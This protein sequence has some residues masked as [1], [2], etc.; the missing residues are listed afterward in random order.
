MLTEKLEILD[1]DSDWMLTNNILST[2]IKEYFSANKN[3][4]K[5]LEAGCG[6]RWRINLD[7]IN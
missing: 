1:V 3:T 2:F 5:I 7:I 4:I 6:K